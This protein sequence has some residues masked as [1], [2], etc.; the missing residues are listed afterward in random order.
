MVRLNLG[1]WSFSALASWRPSPRSTHVNIPSSSLGYAYALPSSHGRSL[2]SSSLSL[3]NT[4]KTACLSHARHNNASTGKSFSQYAPIHAQRGGNPADEPLPTYFQS[5]AEGSKDTSASFQEAKREDEVRRR[6]F[7]RYASRVF[8][9]L[10]TIGFLS[11][12]YWQNLAR[13][14]K[15]E[16]LQAQVKR[17]EKALESSHPNRRLNPLVAELLALPQAFLEL[18][19]IFCRL[20]LTQKESLSRSLLEDVVMTRTEL[21]MILV[22]SIKM[23]IAK[24]ASELTK[25]TGKDYTEELV[26]D[27]ERHDRYLL[28]DRLE[29]FQSVIIE[30][31]ER[32]TGQAKEEKQEEKPENGNADDVSGSG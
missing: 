32:E 7:F 3:G 26:A 23:G 1:S 9:L 18:G 4:I 28:E 19:R 8:W 20:Y 31:Y 22:S 27:L 10:F 16:R 25:I 11:E 5:Q 21:Q 13:E 12:N 15:V 24:T 30:L 2:K 29:D 6:K 14:K 17:K